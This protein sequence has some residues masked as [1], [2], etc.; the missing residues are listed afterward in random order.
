L[1]PGPAPMKAVD[2]QKRKKLDDRMVA[3]NAQLSRFYITLTTTTHCPSLVFITLKRN[4]YYIYN[5]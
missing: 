4:N 3:H 5:N 1:T 2:D